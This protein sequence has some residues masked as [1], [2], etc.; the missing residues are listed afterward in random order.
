MIE[1]KDNDILYYSH[2]LSDLIKQA[3][4]N[5]IKV[6]VEETDNKNVISFK[7]GLECISVRFNIKK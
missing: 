2:K 7:K 6:I 4:Y 3:N 1:P 5:G